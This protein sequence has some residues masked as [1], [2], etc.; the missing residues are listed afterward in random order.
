MR[1]IITWLF[2]SQWGFAAF[3][4]GYTIIMAVLWHFHWTAISS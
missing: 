3:V 1:K 2:D 4:L